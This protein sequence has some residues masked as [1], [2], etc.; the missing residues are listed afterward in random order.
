MGDDD[1]RKYSDIPSDPADFIRWYQR[2]NYVR[3]MIEYNRRQAA[4]P[5]SIT[6]FTILHDDWCALLDGTG[7]CDCCP[8]IAPGRPEDQG[9]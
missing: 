7:P 5:G 6:E 2:N 4:Q 3:P 9:D 1:D 8:E